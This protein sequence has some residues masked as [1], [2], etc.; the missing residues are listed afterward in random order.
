[1]GYIEGIAN[2]KVVDEVRTRLQNINLDSILESGYVEQLIED[3]PFSIFPTVG[4]SEKPDKVASKLLEGRV[5][6]LCDGTPFVLTVPF[7]YY[8][9]ITSRRGLLLPALFIL[10]NSITKIISSIH[11]CC[12][13]ALLY[14]PYHLSSRDG[15]FTLTGNNGCW[16]RTCP[17]PYLY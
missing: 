6:I 2:E 17:F 8:R 10:L 4:N 12:G 3:S 16:G 7:L 9:G 11:C 1:M 13:H 15:S 14:R 5:A